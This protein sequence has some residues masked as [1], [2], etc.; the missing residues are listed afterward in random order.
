MNVRK[1][2]KCRRFFGAEDYRRHG[3]D[4]KCGSHENIRLQ[5]PLAFSDVIRNSG[6]I[7]QS[8]IY[9]DPIFISCNLRNFT[10]NENETKQQDTC[11]K[12]TK[13][14]NNNLYYL[15]ITAKENQ[16]AKKQE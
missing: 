8:D 1:I 9:K 16:E 10:K 15:T 3:L 5:K 4:P 12:T 14:L 13:I 11:S 6:A 2:R 7:R